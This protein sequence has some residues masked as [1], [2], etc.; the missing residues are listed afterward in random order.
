[1]MLTPSAF[2][3]KWRGS[4]RTESAASQEHF[5]DLCRMLGVETPNEADPTGDWYAFEKGA[6]KAGGGDGFADVWKRGHFAWEYKG[7]RKDLGAAYTQ[8]L[9]YKDSLDNPPLLVVCDLDRF[10]VHT[11]F[12][13]T[14]KQVYRF[15]LED[16]ARAPQEPLRILRAVL[17]EPFA[18]RP[19]ETREEL[20]E[21][22]AGDFAALAQALR[23]RGHEPQRVAHFLN[24]LLFCMF[25]EDAGLLPRAVVRRVIE[26]TRT[27]PAGLTSA[28]AELFGKMSDQGGRFGAEQIQWFNGGLFDG[29]DVLPL[30]IGDAEMIRRVSLLDWSQVEPAIFGTLF[31]RGLDPGKRSQLGAHYTDRESIERVIEP[32]V[33]A[34]LRRE[35]AAVQAIALKELE[36]VSL[37]GHVQGPALRQRTRAIVRASSH[38]TRFLERLEGVRVLDPACGSGNFLYMALQALKGLEKEVSLWAAERLHIPLALPRIS[39]AVLRGIELNPYAAE[40]ARVSIWIGEIQWMLSNGFAYLRDPVLRPLHSI[41][42]RDA[43]LENGEA[44]P[45]EPAWPDAEYIIGNPPFLGGKLMRLNLG[46]D[47][48]DQLFTVYEGRVPREADFVTYWHEKARS[49]VAAGKA[50]RVGLLATQGIR[51]GANRKVLARIKETG[52]IFFAWS[53]EPWV[54]EGAAVHVSIIGY[55]DGTETTRTLD[56]EPVTEINSDLTSGL[57][58]TRARRLR[59]NVGIAFMGDTKGGP[60]DIADRVALT[61]LEKSNPHGKSNSEVIRPWVNGLDIAGRPR[62]VQII[63]FGTDMSAKEAALYE[64]P[65]EY[66]RERVQPARAV[67]RTTISGRWWLH[68][69]PR[70]EMREALA[71]LA[72]YIATPRVSKHRLFVWLRANTLADSATIV[73][74]R[75]DDFFFGVL[76][77]GVHELWAR[78]TGTQVRERESGFRYT[79]STTFETFPF[80]DPTNAQR[81]EIATAAKQLDT[82]R[83]GWLNPGE[84]LDV[85]DRTLTNLYNSSPTWLRDAHRNLDQAVYAAYGW[86]YPLDDDAVLSRLLELNLS[87]SVHGRPHNELIVADAEDAYRRA[88]ITERERPWEHRPQIDKTIALRTTRYDVSRVPL[89]GGYVAKQCP[90]RAQNDAIHPAEP[91]PPDPFIERLFANGNAFEAEVVAEVLELNPHTVSVQGSDADDRETATVAAIAAGASPILNAR[92]PADLG[93]RRVGKLD[94]LVAAASGGYRAVDIKWHQTLQPSTG[95]ASELPGLCAGLDML[96][97]EMAVVDP[98]FAAKKREDDLLQLAH[99]QR[100]LEASGLAA[101]GPRLGGIIGTERRVVWY[102]LDMPMWRTPSSTG[103]TKLRTT[104]E[105]YDF[106]FHFRL[107]IVAVAEQHKMDPAIEL[108]VVPVRCGE[109]PTCPWNDYCQPILNA[110]SGDVSLLPRVGWTQWKVHREHGVTD[111]AALAALDWRTA[112]IVAAGID[113]FGLQAA[114]VALRTDASVIDLMSAGAS[115]KQLEQLQDL[116]IHTVGDLLALDVATA[117]YSRSGLTSLPDQIDMARAAL[118]NEPVYRRRGVDQIAVPRADIEVD[119]DMENSEVG[120]YLWGNLLTDRTNPEALRSEYIPFRTWEPLTPEREA[121]NSYAFWRWLMGVR[122]TARARSLSFCA[123]CYSAGAENQYLRRLGISKDIADDVEDFIGSNEWVDLLRLW[124]SQLITGAASGLKVVAPLIGFQWDV[125]DA[126]GVES[127]LRY[128]AAVAGDDAARRWLL[129]YNRGDVQATLTVREWMGSTA[130]PSVEARSRK[131]RDR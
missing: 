130:V 96:A 3:I 66:V 88:P 129:D 69:R 124:D 18:L 110:G 107:D 36:G 79:P 91:T 43:V 14:T 99:Y 55:D 37:R 4:T 32:V 95:K 123:Y 108:L 12:T 111:R 98:N 33:I 128:D 21:R 60:F 104:M 1:M 38:V 16:L 8:L 63:D 9:Q 31:E 5:I 26:G 75:D 56:G 73:F 127:I 121:E 77:S 35:F 53:D 82:W 42:C 50:L 7:K 48:V 113:V 13:N 45:A 41:E 101:E 80:P 105:R 114:A 119:I 85:T 94:V 6:E 92:L 49:M 59:E 125:D 122:E 44:G 120:V 22:A 74:A 47:Y 76:H 57:D 106:E 118:G 46:D 58:L 34:P 52:D 93:G 90:V 115:A 10:E 24:K 11:N 116:E 70:P 126:G 67:S 68:E 83:S 2:A 29:D 40:L 23:T 28:L 17:S 78:R 89:Q 15:S 103:R 112:S 97:G 72:R 71:G 25:A 86:S 51:G 61:M 54:V 19:G 62:N 64:A 131:Q 30:D 65:F 87:Q 84:T 117:R 20:T 100:M 81:Q 39:P 27:D 109:C 102:D